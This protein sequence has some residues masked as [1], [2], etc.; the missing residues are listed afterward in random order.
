M[1]MKN[2]LFM[3]VSSFAYALNLGFVWEKKNG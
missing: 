1:M 3:K 2:L